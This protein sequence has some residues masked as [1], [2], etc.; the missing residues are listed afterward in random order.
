LPQ[1]KKPPFL[2]GAADHRSI[3]STPSFIIRTVDYH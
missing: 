3:S 2:L 1:A